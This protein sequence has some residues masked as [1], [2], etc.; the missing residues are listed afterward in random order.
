MARERRQRLL[1][2]AAARRVAF[3]DR[4]L[5]GAGIHDLAASHHEDAAR[6]PH[7]DRA[8]AE[9]RLDR[10]EPDA[11]FEAQLVR[12]GCTLGSYRVSHNATGAL[13]C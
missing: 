2:V 10:D 13:K 9:G 5:D 7:K 11:V 6:D 12:D 1:P 4:A 8:V 3:G